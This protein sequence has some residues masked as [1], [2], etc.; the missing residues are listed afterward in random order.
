MLG[1][2][3]SYLVYGNR[4][5][6]VEHGTQNGQEIV[7]ATV[8]KKSRNHITLGHTFKAAALDGIV[9]GLRKKQAV[10]LVVNNDHVLTKRIESTQTEAL[11]LAHSAFPNIN[12]DDFF[13][14]IVSRGTGH[15]VSICRR[16]YIEGLVVG[17]NGHGLTVIDVSLGNSL[18]DSIASFLDGASVVT[19]NARIS[20][21]SNVIAS[22]EKM[23]MKDT[24]SYDINGL[25]ANNFQLLSLAAALD[26][27]LGRFRPVT[28]FGTL[29]LSL[30]NGYGQSR[31]FSMGLRFGLVFILGGL[32]INF[33]VFSHY[34]GAVNALQQ[35][36]QMNHTTKQ[37]LLELSESVNRSQKMVDDM[38]KSGSSKSAFYVNAIVHGLPNSIL[39]TE[40]DY[41]PL[42]K[43]IKNGQPV[44]IDSSAIMVSGES[45]DS[46]SFSEWIADMEGFGWVRKVEIVN[47]GDASALV[48][49]FSLKLIM[50]H[51]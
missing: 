25:R 45:N 8:L 14:E 36:S 11:K 21:D 31:F 41:Q 42:L 24:V 50:A 51:D 32:L 18:V 16:A 4:F 5:C 19:S 47:Y 23:D 44:E 29:K 30:K 2:F 37:K 22:I 13:Y 34:F 3:K 46:A 35:T 15:L 20:M 17:Y 49:S 48:S 12:I 33:F 10:F 9:S 43:R 6:G 39:L 27:V 7:Y 40:L 28:N 1:P 38:L 26:I